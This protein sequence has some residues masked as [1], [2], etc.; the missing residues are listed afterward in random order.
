MVDTVCNWDFYRI[1]SQSILQ[2]RKAFYSLHRENDETTDQWLNRVRSSVR[3]CEFP[4]FFKYLMMDRFVC[5][6]NTNELKTIQSAGKYSTLD[7]LV[8]HFTDRNI[9]SRHIEIDLTIDNN[10]NQRQNKSSGIIKEI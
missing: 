6:L 10:I 9:N 2:M 3:N 7:Q 1:P 5:G 4:L 8:D